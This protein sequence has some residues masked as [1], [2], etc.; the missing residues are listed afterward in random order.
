MKPGQ[1]TL[2]SYGGEPVV[3]VKFHT[4]DP[5]NIKKFYLTQSLINH[6]KSCMNLKGFKKFINLKDLY[7]VFNNSFY[8]NR[9]LKEIQENIIED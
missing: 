9:I 3:Y 4:D 7:K 5:I 1:T 6:S 2:K 8:R